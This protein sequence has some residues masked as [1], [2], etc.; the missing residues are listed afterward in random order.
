MKTI[1][2]LTM[3]PSVDKST[4]TK[5][6]VAERKIRCSEP[7]Y[8]PGGGGINISRVIQ[9]LGGDS[10]ALFP[11]GGANGQ[12]L[13]SM[14]SEEGV[15]QYAVPVKNL[16]RENYTVYEEATGLQYRFG[17]PGPEL[18]ETEWRRCL[19]ELAAIIPRPEYLVISGSLPPGVPDD[20][21]AHVIRKARELGARVVLD[22]S[23]DALKQ[24]MREP[25]YLIKPNMAEMRDLAG[26]EIEDES[27]QEAA[28]VKI[29]AS[30]RSEIV[31]VS[32][33]AAG[34]L[35]VTGDR[36]ERLRAPSVPI[37]SKVGAGDSMLAGIVFKLAQGKSTHEAISF[38][39][40]AGTAAVMTPGTE[41]C[42]KEPTERLYRQITS[43]AV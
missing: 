26:Y 17:V 18:S 33:G 39:V 42:Q 15:S 32:L 38:G 9:R 7:I 35:L 10:I 22:T 11:A 2:T 34:A 40:A 24:A 1:A 43:R 19:N 31:V 37:K 28:A 36:C 5:N 41:L 13:Q 14:L 30:G 6:V 29:I 8:E 23:G 20:F 4:T 16:T 3:N 25:V 27:Q 12:L 21:Y